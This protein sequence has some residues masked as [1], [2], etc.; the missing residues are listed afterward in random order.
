MGGT[1]SGH[2]TLVRVEL[3]VIVGQKCMYEGQLPDDS[4]IQKI[5]DW[6]I[7]RSLTEVQGFLGTMGTIRIFIKNYTMHAK[8]LVQL[9]RKA[10]DFGFWEEQV[11]A[12]E[13][14]KYLAKNSPAIR[15]I[16]YLLKNKVVLAMDSSWMVVG[17]I[18][19]QMGDDG[20]RHPSIY[21]SI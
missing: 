10:V 2:K 4:Q 8:P 9:T 21:G 19:S 17:F 7:C 11:L 6:P 3:A 16:D 18:L 1:F 13:K 20:K 5:I 12:I 15:A 14:L